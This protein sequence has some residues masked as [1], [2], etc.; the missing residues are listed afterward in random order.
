MFML[1]LKINKEHINEISSIENAADELYEKESFNCAL[2]ALNLYFNAYNLLNETIY[3][4]D[5]LKINVDYNL[6]KDKLSKKIENT[7][8]LLSDLRLRTYEA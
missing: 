2:S 8:K 4:D 5:A 6:W 7:N 1:Q 3:T